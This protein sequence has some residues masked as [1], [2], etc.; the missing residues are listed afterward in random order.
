M[1]TDASQEIAKY[2][3][4]HNPD[5][6][7]ESTFVSRGLYWKLRLHAACV[8]KGFIPEEFFPC[9][10]APRSTLRALGYH[11]GVKPIGGVVSS[12]VQFNNYFH[13]DLELYIK[14]SGSVYST[15]RS[16]GL[17]GHFYQFPHENLVE[18][19]TPIK[20]L[21]PNVLVDS[22]E[23]APGLSIVLA[24]ER[25]ADLEYSYIPAANSH[26]DSKTRRAINMAMVNS[27]EKPSDFLFNLATN[28]NSVAL[29]AVI[30]HT[31]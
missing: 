11:L 25:C 1:A 23:I 26:P 5:L 3:I 10:C 15:Q 20:P 24:E 7:E 13:L 12:L 19:R 16:G 8:A 17:Y 27:A 30:S 4:P 18:W 9:D 31:Q 21:D 2:N 14:R 6:L 28:N 29:K 22:I